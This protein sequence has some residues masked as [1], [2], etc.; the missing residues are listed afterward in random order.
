MD[1]VD[2]FCCGGLGGGKA[3]W[4]RS[5]GQDILPRVIASTMY[6]LAGLCSGSHGVD[7]RPPPIDSRVGAAPRDIVP[8]SFIGR[9]HIDK[10]ISRCDR[11]RDL[12]H[13]NTK[14]NRRLRLSLGTWR[15]VADR[16]W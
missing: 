8:V 16:Q 4:C 7:A 10:E 5:G 15:P 6:R 11:M 12:Q 14:V 13:A 3:R 1:D 2:G 9:S